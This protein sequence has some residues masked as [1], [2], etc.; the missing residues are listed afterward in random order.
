MTYRKNVAIKTKY[1]TLEACRENCRDIK[2]RLVLPIPASGKIYGELFEG[3]FFVLSSR[4]AKT[5]VIFEFVGQMEDRRDG[6]YLVGEIRTKEYQKWLLV[7]FA[8]LFHVI[9]IG[10][11]AVGTLG[12][13][14]YGVFL[15]IVAW[16]Y[17]LFMWKSDSLYHDLIR[18]V[19]EN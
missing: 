5:S 14:A 18:K 1:K 12:L 2:K 8:I 7:G 10:L 4:K 13:I 6:I 17:I 19:Q 3:D 16:I 9:G 11:I 15:L